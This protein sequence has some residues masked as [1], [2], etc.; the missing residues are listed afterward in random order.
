MLRL[1]LVTLLF[2]LPLIGC[3]K[4][5]EKLPRTKPEAAAAPAAPVEAAPAKAPAPVRAAP[6]AP[7]AAP[8]SPSE[9]G[10]D[11]P[12]VK[13]SANQEIN[14]LILALRDARSGRRVL[15]DLIRRYPQGVSALV[16]GLRHIEPNI[17]TQ[18]AQVLVLLHQKKKEKLPQGAILG[19]VSLVGKDKN[20]H[21]RALGA[22]ALGSS[23]EERFADVLELALQSDR[24]GPVRA[25][26]AKSLGELRAKKAVPSLIR[27]LTDRETEV[28]MYAA[29][30]LRKLKAKEAVTALVQLL[31]D[32][33]TIVRARA[34]KALQE[35]TGKNLPAQP[36]AWRYV[37]P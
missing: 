4:A 27:A 2:C 36:E 24:S 33:N 21:V 12:V 25:A 13:I 17:R 26:A 6:K 16:R 8:S 5:S 10:V 31:G 3:Q 20:E 15:D 14:N 28:R 22:K 23:G 32:P 29:N 30:S 19:L 1:L 37:M 9:E 34:H 7:S 18:C 35:I 11:G